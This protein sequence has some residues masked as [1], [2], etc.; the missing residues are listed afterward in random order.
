MGYQPVAADFHGKV[1]HGI[2]VNEK[3]GGLHDE[4]HRCEAFY[5][6]VFRDEGGDEVGPQESTENQRNRLHSRQQEK[7]VQVSR[8]Q[9]RQVAPRQVSI[10]HLFILSDLFRTRGRQSS[11]EKDEEDEEIF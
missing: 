6:L 7:V 11:Y 3:G 2:L 4:A 8:R 5:G 10:K 1:L 9:I